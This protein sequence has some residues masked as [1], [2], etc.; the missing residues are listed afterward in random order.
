MDVELFDKASAAVADE[1]ARLLAD[2][3]Y[4]RVDL[5]VSFIMQSGLDLIQPDLEDALPRGSG[6]GC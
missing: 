5:G 3:R 1:V 2:R 6:C 4:D